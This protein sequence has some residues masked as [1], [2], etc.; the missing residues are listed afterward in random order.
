[1][2]LA[3]G[4][5]QRFDTMWVGSIPEVTSG[6]SREGGDCELETKRDK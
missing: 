2:D 5:Y 1:M 6:Y 4:K 3:S